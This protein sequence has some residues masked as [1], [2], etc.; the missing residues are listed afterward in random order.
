MKYPSKKM[1]E[2]FNLVL[3]LEGSCLRYEKDSSDGEITTYNLVVNDKY[4][5]NC[6]KTILNVTT[7][8]ENKVRSFFKEYGIENIGYTN[9]VLIIFTSENI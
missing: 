3:Q 6:Y 4:I 2:H 7:E 5:N 8:F 1:I 9:T